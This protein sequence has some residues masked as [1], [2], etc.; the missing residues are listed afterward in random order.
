MSEYTKF[1][2]R[3]RNFFFSWQSEYINI[4][5]KLTHSVNFSGQKFNQKTWTSQTAFNGLSHLVLGLHMV[6]QQ[7]PTCVCNKGLFG[8]IWRTFM[9][10]QGLNPGYSDSRKSPQCL[11]YSLEPIFK[12]YLFSIF[13]LLN[14]FYFIPDM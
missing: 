14:N 2:V 11:N 1:I 5:Q 4:K 6:V 3:A 12:L 9:G 8:R 7:V 10:L 13:I